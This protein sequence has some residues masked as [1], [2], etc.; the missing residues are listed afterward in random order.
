MKKILK[1]EK[2]I[3]CLATVIVITKRV[4]TWC[5]QSF[6][7]RMIAATMAA[8]F[9]LVGV[10][11]TFAL[12]RVQAQGEVTNAFQSAKI[13]VQV[14]EE[15][16]NETVG[17]DTTNE[18]DFGEITK[19]EP[20][21]KKVQIENVHSEA[22]PTTDTFVRCRIVPIVRDTDGNN[23]AVKVDY[24]LTGT[25]DD[26]ITNSEASGETYYYWKKVLPKGAKTDY[27]FQNVIVTSDIP[28]GA[29][30]ELQ[31]LTDA[32]QARPYAATT[33]EEDI[34]K[35]PVYQAWSWYYD[36]TSETLKHN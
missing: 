12:L 8:T 13:N 29:H 28:A 26:W 10:G 9:V 22:Y 2:V 36:T 33:T 21:E 18:V 16:Q 24:E 15:K 23:I 1:S 14:V 31:V 6:S 3:H 35:T 7:K 17:S 19:N 32:V 5:E 27:L 11:T 30:L 25:A 34:K 20:T 4:Q